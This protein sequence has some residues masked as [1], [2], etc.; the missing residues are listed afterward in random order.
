MIPREIQVEHWPERT[1]YDFPGRPIG[2]L[3]Y[4]GLVPM[5]FSLAFVWFPL[6]M[7]RGPFRELFSGKANLAEL[8]AFVFVGVFVLVAL[9]PFSF[10]LF[11]LAGRTR[12]VV[13]RDRLTVTQVAGPI[14]RSSKIRVSQIHRLEFRAP[15]RDNP[16]RPAPAWLANLGGLTAQ[17][18]NGKSRQL[19]L[20]YPSD[21]IEPVAEELTGFLR[22]GGATVSVERVE[23]K[24]DTDA[25]VVV[26]E[27]VSKPVDTRVR[28]ESHANGLVMEV[29]PSGLRRGAR[30]LFVFGLCWCGALG[31]ITW[32][33]RA[34]SGPPLGVYLF[35]AVF[36]LIGAAMLATSLS[37]A[38]RRATLTCASRA[39]TVEQQG[40]FGKKVRQWRSGEI[41]ALRAGPSGMA[42]NNQPLFE[43]QIHPVVGRNVGLLTGR[44]EPELRWLASELRQALG[45]PAAENAQP[46]PAVGT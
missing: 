35:F 29:P 28:M 44:P 39:L 42:V 26:E 19:L 43:L 10:G 8:V 25:A 16:A 5:L 2:K 38:R 12:L 33:A 37:L 6:Q 40:L 1:T 27:V 46:A 11:L 9:I 41:A 24:H 32:L 20:G 15:A 13:T 36:W 21:W 31:L 4:F 23:M 7:L 30:G 18:K 34:S 22:L 14:R 45:V 17:L 3:R